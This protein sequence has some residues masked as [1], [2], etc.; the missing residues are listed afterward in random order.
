MEE[1]TRFLKADVVVGFVVGTPPP[2]EIRPRAGQASRGGTSAPRRLRRSMPPGADAAA[3]ARRADEL[4][5]ACVS[6]L[7]RRDACGGY[8]GHSGGRPTTRKETDSDW[9]EI[10]QALRLHFAGH[11]TIGLHSTDPISGGCRWLA[12]DIDAHD[13]DAEPEANMQAAEQIVRRLAIRG[14]ESR[15]L[16][17]DGRGGLHVWCPLCWPLASEEAFDLAH[18]TIE[19]LAVHVEAFPKQPSIAPDGY[20]NWIRLPGHHHKRT[21]WSRVWLPDD[22]RWGSADE[23]I[24]ALLELM[25]PGSGPGNGG[26]R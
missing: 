3:W 5:A 15:I 10:G 14:T 11:R 8:R 13:A 6:M 25:A 7:N 16:D 18:Q 23:T 19:G 1:V 9:I 12:F 21:H 4:A 20:G 24:D 26:A 2:P 17:S 22:E